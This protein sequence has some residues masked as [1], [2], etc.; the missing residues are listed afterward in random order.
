LEN[1]YPELRIPNKDAVGWGAVKQKID[2]KDLCIAMYE[3]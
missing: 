2:G 1:V 3:G